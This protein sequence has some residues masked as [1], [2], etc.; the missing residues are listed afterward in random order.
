MKDLYYNIVK[1]KF[2]P[3][4]KSFAV[5]ISASDISLNECHNYETLDEF[6]GIH[7]AMC[8]WEKDAI[9][10]K[11]IVK[12]LNKL[13]MNRSFRLVLEGEIAVI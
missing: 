4:V 7:D 12:E 10:I 13:G 2:A 3:D 9:N 8:I 1:R 11:K 5:Y 6:L